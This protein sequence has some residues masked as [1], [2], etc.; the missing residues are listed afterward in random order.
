[1]TQYVILCVLGAVFAEGVSRMGAGLLT[2]C[3]TRRMAGLERFGLGFLCG[4]SALGMA[5]LGLALVGLF[6]PAALAGC[7]LVLVAGSRATWSREA[8]LASLISAARRIGGPGIAVVAAAFGSLL[9]LLLA[10]PLLHDDYLYDL[11]VPWQY[12]QAHR[13]TH[14][15]VPFVFHYPLLMNMPFALAL[16]SGADRLAKWMV[17]ACFVAANAVFAGARLARGDRTSA[18]LGPVLALATAPVLWL[19]SGAKSDL[20]AASLFVAGALVSRTGAWVLSGVLFGSAC[21]AKMTCVPVVAVWIALMAATARREGEVP[22]SGYLRRFVFYLRASFALKRLAW[23]VAGIGVVLA[24]WGVKTYL[25]TGNPVYPFASSL[26]PSLE[27]GLTN[28][29]VLQAMLGAKRTVAE[30]LLRLPVLWTNRLIEDYLVLMLVVPGLIFLGRRCRILITLVASQLLTLWAH[31]DGRY[32]LPSAWLILLIAAEEAVRL[33]G[34]L[35]VGAISLLAGVSLLQ[36]NCQPRECNYG[37]RGL[38][39]P[40]DELLLDRFTTYEEVVRAMG[41][42]RAPLRLL[43][44]GERLVYRLPARVVHTGQIG[45]TPLLWKIAHESGDLPEFAKRIRQIGATRLLHNFISDEWVSLR[46]RHFPWKSG[47]LAVYRE[48][49]RTRL[50]IVRGP[51]HVDNAGGGHYLYAIHAWPRPDAPGY[52]FFLPGAGWVS[53]SG[54]IHMGPTR[55]GDAIREYGELEK[56]IPDI[57]HFHSELAVAYAGAGRWAEAMDLLEPFIERGMIDG[58]NLP[59]YAEA[60]INLGRV[61]LAER[62]LSECQKVYP[63]NPYPTMA[64]LA[65]VYTERGRRLL[66][67]GRAAE[68]E[69]FLNRA[70]EL[71]FAIP[72]NCS[73]KVAKCLPLAMAD[74]DAV[75]GDIELTRGRR[76]EARR[77]YQ[78][79]IQL[80]PDSSD[81]DRWRWKLRKVSGSGR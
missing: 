54:L 21:A 50:S 46:Y 76:E 23:I 55:L 38:L 77:F 27:W 31:G 58:L 6:F 73:A 17:V 61:N 3:L 34:L 12:L 4:W 33:R 67:N 71:L 29:A 35:R 79:A 60:A 53:P 66:A 49:C 75:Q 14:S 30:N 9:P 78:K 19:L 48:F 37:W 72:G 24:P 32:L 44:V 63:C 22:P 80:A 18:W 8:L 43:T 42:S 2:L 45:E 39:V 15:F 62:W 7:F 59:T 11:G 64:N 68:C 47:A 56:V 69:R 74:I 1:M 36:V 16:G 10:P 40:Q 70:R 41:T 13:A 28:E 51:E 20:M 5:F 25:V 81:A 57:G 65:V 26:F 52:A